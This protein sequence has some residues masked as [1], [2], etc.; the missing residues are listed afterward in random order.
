MKLNEEHEVI[1]N[2]M[3]LDI[4]W[5]VWSDGIRLNMKSAELF[6]LYDVEMK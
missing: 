5:R 1:W 2:G 4:T 6:E 3:Q